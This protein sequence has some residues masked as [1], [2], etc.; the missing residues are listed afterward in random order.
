MKIGKNDALIVVDVQNDFCP[1][2]A[3]SVKN[4]DLI[5]KPLNDAMKYFDN[6]ITTQDWHPKNHISFK[7]YG[8]VWPPHCVA[9][10]LGSNLHKDLDSEK[11]TYRV[12]KGQNKNK[13]A[14]SGFDGTDLSEYLKNSGIKR[15]FVGG[16]ATDYCVKA[17]AL[18]SIEEG[19]ETYI[20]EDIVRGVNINSG[21]DKRALEEIKENGGNII[22]TSDL[23]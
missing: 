6:I 18:D 19:F 22:K 5:V 8:G 11:V 3:L 21:D 9:E 2:G 16:L 1:G 13:D 10:S 4:G 7:K 15:V 12:Y 20:L 14:Y 23:E 17:T